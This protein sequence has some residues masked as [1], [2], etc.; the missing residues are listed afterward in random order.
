[1]HPRLILLA[2][3]AVGAAACSQQD[4]KARVPTR[5]VVGTWRS[6]TLAV[7]GAAPRTFRLLVREDGMAEL[8][9]REAGAGDSL[10]ERGTWDGADSLLRVVVRGEGAGTRATSI[11]LAIRGGNAMAQV[12]FDSAQWGDGLV[13]HRQ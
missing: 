8:A 1:M 7:A 6:D 11:L 13:F 12:E 5:A 2:A 10:V 3:L 4:K 9:R